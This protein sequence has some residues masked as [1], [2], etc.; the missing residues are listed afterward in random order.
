MGDA[1]AALDRIRKSRAKVDEWEQRVEADVVAAYRA[2]ATLA[3]LAEVM[4]VRSIE[5]PRQLLLRHNVTLRS[6][7]RAKQ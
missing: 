4:E 7:G 1:S 6:P 2:G 5:T 3:Q